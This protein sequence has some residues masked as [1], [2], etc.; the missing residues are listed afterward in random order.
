MKTKFCGICHKQKKIQEFCKDDRKLGGYS[1]PCKEC[2]NKINN[3]YREKNKEKLRKYGRQYKLKNKKRIR[4]VNKIWEK[5]NI[6][7]RTKYIKKWNMIHKTH[8][9]KKLLER[10][11]FDINFKISHNLRTRIYD[12]LKRNSKSKSTMKLLD[13][14]IPELKQHLEKQFKKD[15]TWDNYGYYGWHID[16]I[17]QCYKFDLS[18]PEEQ[19]KCFN[20]KNLRPLWAKENLSR[21]RKR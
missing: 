6:E 11:K 16:H 13:C 10:R 2:H 3:I 1:S 18:K 9:N 21:R 17:K 4:K 15:M 12:A 5:N 7:K 20:Y 14:T 19:R 8:R